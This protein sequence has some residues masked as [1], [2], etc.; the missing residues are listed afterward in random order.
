MAT[1]GPIPAR[2]IL[3][4]GRVQISALYH[5]NCVSPQA[6]SPGPLSVSPCEISDAM[7]AERRKDVMNFL[8]RM[9]LS[10][11]ALVHQLDGAGHLHLLPG[12]LT[13]IHNLHNASLS[14]CTCDR[15]LLGLS[16]AFMG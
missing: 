5:A 15:F 11:L 6:A 16:A 10:H 7:S 3:C 9:V 2:L 14:P 4:V 1:R 12:L 8:L 13:H